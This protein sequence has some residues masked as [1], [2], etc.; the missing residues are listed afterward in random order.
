MENTTI[1]NR[2]AALRADRG[3]SRKDLAQI[4][5]VNYQTIGYIERGDYKPSLVLAL[6]MAQFF[7]VPVE[8]IFS[9]YPLKPLSEYI[10]NKES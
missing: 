7:E 10:S 3:L 4:L 5:S 6:Q 1:Y 8:A 2:V 9:L